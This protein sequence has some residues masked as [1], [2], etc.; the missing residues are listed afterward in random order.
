MK[1]EGHLRYMHYAARDPGE[2]KQAGVPTAQG[3]SI[4]VPLPSY[5]SNQCSFADARIAGK[6]EIGSAAG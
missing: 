4:W 2:S 5:F 1:G 3:T 6:L